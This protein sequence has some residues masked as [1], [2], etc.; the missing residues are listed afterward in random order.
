MRTRVDS[1][2]QTWRSC[3]DMVRSWW[4]ILAMAWSWQEHGMVIM[5]YSMIMVWPSWKN[6]WTCHGD[7]GHYYNV[8]RTLINQPTLLISKQ[9][10]VRYFL[11]WNML[12][13]PIRNYP[14][15][16]GLTSIKK[17]WTHKLSFMAMDEVMNVIHC[18]IKKNR[19]HDIHG[20]IQPMYD[21]ANG[22]ISSKILC[23]WSWLS[24]LLAHSGPIL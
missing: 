11:I 14:K 7:H 12:Y 13:E 20:F 18:T 3:Y 24:I 1:H 19:C 4:F 17:Q 8:V 21:S 9:M 6:A 23:F 2:G 16:P 15:N 5:K 10:V 22:K